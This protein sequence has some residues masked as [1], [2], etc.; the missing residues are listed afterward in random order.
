MTSP[1]RAE[2]ALDQF[3]GNWGEPR[4][5]PLPTTRRLTMTPTS[6][7]EMTLNRT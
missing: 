4:A 7:G 2:L 3:D 5:E 6:E 1:V